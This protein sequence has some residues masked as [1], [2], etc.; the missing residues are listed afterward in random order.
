MGLLTQRKRRSSLE[1]NHPFNRD[2]VDPSIH[3]QQRSISLQKH[4]HER[5]GAHLRSSLNSLDS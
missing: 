1:T 2:T 4:V 3:R 5:V